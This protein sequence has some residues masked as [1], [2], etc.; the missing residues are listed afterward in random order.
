MSIL[1]WTWTKALEILS[2]K[3]DGLHRKNASNVYITF[4]TKPIFALWEFV[5]FRTWKEAIACSWTTLHICFHLNHGWKIF[6]SE[7]YRTL[8]PLLREVNMRWGTLRLSNNSGLSQSWARVYG[9]KMTSKALKQWYNSSCSKLGENHLSEGPMTHVS[10]VELKVAVHKQAC[11]FKSNKKVGIPMGNA[12]YILQPTTNLSFTMYCSQIHQ[13]HT[14]DHIKIVISR[15]RM[16][17]IWKCQRS[18]RLM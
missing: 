2:Q 11:S 15:P 4:Q 17:S 8:I 18:R 16:K 7:S 1:I 12:I 9:T 3:A 10:K 14:E 5:I 6:L 13:K